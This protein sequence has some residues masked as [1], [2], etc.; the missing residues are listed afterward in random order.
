M[1]KNIRVCGNNSV[2]LM[3]CFNTNKS[4]RLSWFR[5]LR[6]NWLLASCFNFPILKPLIF[7]IFQAFAFLSG[8]IHSLKPLLETFLS[9]LFSLFINPKTFNL[10]NPWNSR[11]HYDTNRAPL[12]LY[13]HTLWF[14]QKKNRAAF[15]K[16][17]DDMVIL[18][19]FL[20]IYFF[21]IIFFSSLYFFLLII[22]F[23][24]IICFPPDYM[25]F[26]WLYVFFS[27]YMFFF[28]L[29]VFS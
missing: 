5:F 12:G 27:D 15:R 11:R 23:F 6:K 20:F 19:F 1:N 10:F 2:P 22:C 24:L 26:S 16:F 9:F 29:Y 21:L 18:S 3:I 8:R 7:L 14:K 28:W 17:L 4:K 25:F 13:F